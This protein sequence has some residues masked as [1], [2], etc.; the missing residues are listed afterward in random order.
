VLEHTG[1]GVRISGASTK[2]KG[3]GDLIMFNGMLKGG[4][5]KDPVGKV[6]VTRIVWAFSVIV[7]ITTWS[8]I[9]FM[10]N[11]FQSFSMGDAAWFTALF[12]GKV[13]QSYVEK[14]PNRNADVSKICSECGKPLD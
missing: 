3:K 6:S 8:C 2:Q 14:T 11:E 9:S 4:V 5:F 12:G 7:I 1:P 13:L 10:T